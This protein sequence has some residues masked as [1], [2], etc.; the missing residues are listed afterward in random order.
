MNQQGYRVRGAIKE[1]GPAGVP[2]APDREEFPRMKR[3]IVS[4]A[5]MAAALGPATDSAHAGGPYGHS[6][7]GP[8]GA[9]FCVR[10]Y[11]AFSPVASGHLYLDGV[12][13]FGPGCCP[14]QQHAPC[15]DP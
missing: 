10:Q 5:L 11:N 3:L 2:S 15:A 9:S 4:A 7:C 14:Q 13:P 6:K 12:L 8:C 1:G